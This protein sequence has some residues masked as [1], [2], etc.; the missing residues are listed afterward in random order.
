MSACTNILFLVR[1]MCL[2]TSYLW[3]SE[4]TRYFKPHFGSLIDGN[5]QE[6]G[7]KTSMVS[8]AL[9]ETAASVAIAATVVGAAATILARRTKASEATEVCK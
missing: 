7:R 2:L 8:S 9:P 5:L 4:V 6:T 3:Y 1:H